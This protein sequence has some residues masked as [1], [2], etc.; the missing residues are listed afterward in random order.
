M[1]RD[2]GF[3]GTVFSFKGKTYSTLY[4]FCSLGGC[5]DGDGP[6]APAIADPFGNLY[7]TGALPRER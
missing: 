5:A 2:A 6:L 7:G 3:G 1:P 4:T